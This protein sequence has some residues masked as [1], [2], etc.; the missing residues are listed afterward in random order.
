MTGSTI[1]FLLNVVYAVN[2]DS[3]YIF[4]HKIKNNQLR[5][6][7]IN[8]ACWIC[9]GDS[10]FYIRFNKSVLLLTFNE[11]GRLLMCIK[12]S[13]FNEREWRGRLDWDTKQNFY[14]EKVQQN[15]GSQTLARNG[16]KGL[17]NDLF[18]GLPDNTSTRN[19]RY[20][21]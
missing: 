19:N 7:S 16:F 13:F 20:L 3:Y 4:I 15:A 12:R 14:K 2:S 18:H 1:K 10:Y 6:M 9:G 8:S 11:F 21:F 5:I 17:V